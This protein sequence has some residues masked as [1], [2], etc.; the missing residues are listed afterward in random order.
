MAITAHEVRVVR[1][2]RS[3]AIGPAALELRALVGDT[4]GLPDAALENLQKIE[5][6]VVLM[7]E[8]RSFDHMLGYLRLEA[9]RTEV[10]GL[11]HGMQNAY[12]GKKYPI[13]KLQNTAL[14]KA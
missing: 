13:R 14:D 11:Q 10:D 8:N 2:S 6:V 4:R 12:Q 7:L 1:T 9:G 5:H 3:A